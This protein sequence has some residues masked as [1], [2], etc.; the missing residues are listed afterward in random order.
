MDTFDRT[1]LLALALVLGC[2]VPVFALTDAEL[3]AVRDG[4]A[5]R[6]DS[7][8][9]SQIAKPYPNPDSA[10]TGLAV[11]GKQD[12]ALAALYNNTRLAEANQAIVE[13]CHALKNDPK[14]Y[15]ESFHWRGNLFYRLYKFF[16]Q[17]SACYPGRLTPE[18]QAAICDVFWNWAKRESRIADAEVALSRTWY[19]RDSE[20][21]DAQ[22][23]TTS[24]SAAEILK[25]QAP[26]CLYRYDDGYTAEQHYEAWNAYFKEYLR[27]RAKKG[28]LVEIG[29]HTYSKYTLQ[30]WYNFYDFAEDA[31]LRTLAGMT[32]DLWWADWSHDQIN[33]VRGGGKTRIYQTRPDYGLHGS[34][35][36]A[37]DDSAYS[38]S[39]YYFNHGTPKSQHPG[40]M[41]LVTSPYRL[42]LVVMD[43]ALDRHGRGVY[44]YLSRRPG[45]KALPPPPGLPAD[46]YGLDPN[47]GGILRYTYTTPE[48]VMGS[49]MCEKR[50]SEDWTAIS[51][52]NRWQGVIFAR[53]PDARILPQCEG[54]PLNYGKTYNQYWSVQNRG[55]LIT[56]K[57]DDSLSRHTGAMR[58]YFSGPDTGMTLVE[59]EGWIFVEVG[60]AFAA[61]KPAWGGYTW[62]DPQWMRLNDEYAPVIIDVAESVDH[63]YSFASFIRAVKALPLTVSARDGI[64]QYTGLGDAGTFTFHIQG[65]QLPNVDGVPIDLQPSFTFQS[66]FMN[67]SFASGMVS[68]VKDRR[69]RHYDFN[70][71]VMPIS[72]REPWLPGEIRQN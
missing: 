35:L 26:Y 51:S 54:I 18:A 57:I 38:M 63:Q 67:E 58:V 28:L 43:I 24:Y 46:T 22:R 32:L 5:A 61:V 66:P 34:D 10:D 44:E 56:Q 72:I 60:N 8:L 69:A 50:S 14:S 68:I 52:Q 15:R 1:H 65:G 9:A 59:E 23:D 27:E 41:C 3:T 49:L 17:D 36:F 19:L 39:W 25:S 16:G 33:G 55:T 45:L 30:G 13:A 71:I 7:C 2:V 70:R 62:A 40:V 47:H 11:W 53:H 21:H 4:F 6:R 29:S 64:L 37:R 48:F 42:P 12:F 31:K 20:N